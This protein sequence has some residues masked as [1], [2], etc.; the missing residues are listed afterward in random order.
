MNNFKWK[1][2]SYTRKT[3]G[4]SLLLP[5]PTVMFKKKI[6]TLVTNNNKKLI[7]PMKI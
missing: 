1:E 3:F 2:K 7:F 6:V 4:E 5:Q